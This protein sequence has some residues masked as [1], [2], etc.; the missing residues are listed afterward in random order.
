MNSKLPKISV[1]P[2]TGDLAKAVIAGDKKAYAEFYKNVIPVILGYIMGRYSADITKEDG[3]DIL[4][5]VFVR[6]MGSPFKTENEG[7]MATRAFSCWIT[8]T[9]NSVYIDRL[10]HETAQKRDLHLRVPAKPDSDQP[11]IDKEAGKKVEQGDF[12]KSIVIR[13]AVDLALE[14][15]SETESR[16]IKYY[17]T[18]GYSVE[19]TAERFKMRPAGLRSMITAFRKELSEILKKYQNICR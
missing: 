11:V 18:M 19:K 15:Y 2:N 1:P 14:Y 9:V 16:A 3:E 8:K 10:R 4:G 13:R 17:F 12:S 7:E 5:E 6:M